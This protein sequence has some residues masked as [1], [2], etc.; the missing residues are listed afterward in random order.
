MIHACSVPFLLDDII[1]QLKVNI[2]F[3]SL[4]FDSIRSASGTSEHI[5][6]T[7]CEHA[8]GFKYNKKCKY[9]SVRC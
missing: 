5:L 8:I 3:N 9:V 1:N 4:N 7:I 2:R 6:K